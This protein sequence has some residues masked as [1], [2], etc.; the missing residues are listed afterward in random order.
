MQRCGLRRGS[1]LY[2]G[3]DMPAVW[4]MLRSVGCKLQCMQQLCGVALQ[5]RLP[6]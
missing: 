4:V 3:V 1:W 6:S 2:S 5:M